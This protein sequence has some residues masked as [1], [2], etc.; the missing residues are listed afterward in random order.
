[1]SK[2]KSLLSELTNQIVAAIEEADFSE[3]KISELIES[4]VSEGQNE[5]FE[6]LKKNAP[7]ML[8]EERRAK[9]S[10]EDRNYRRWKE[11]LDLLR[12]MWV[13]CQEI[14]ESHAH[15]GPLD[16]DELT[17]DTLAHLQPKA[18]LILSEILSLLES[19]FADGALARWRS[20]HEVTV[21]GMFISKHGHEAAL[22]Y[23][24][25]MWF[26]NL[27]AANQYNRH[28]NRANLAPITHAE[29][30][31]IE[32]KCA[33]SRELLG[34]E[35]KSD[36]DWASSILKKTRP[37][38]A[39]LEREVGLDH[40]RPRFKWA[41]QHIH[42]GFVRPDRLLGMTEADNFA[43]QVGASNSGLVE[44]LQ[45]SAISLMQITNTFLL[46]PEPNV[47]RL[48]FANVLAAFSDEIGMV[49]LR[50]KDETLKEALKDA[51]E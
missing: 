13:C 39:D 32:Q 44:P 38:F 24:L 6:S 34:R 25:S 28:A 51:R 23:R 4:I 19:G 35:L 33:E 20:L 27:R 47:D 14:A 36:W 43:F 18:L 3:D 16:G 42:A 30:S 1:M 50:T 45:M 5:L 10:F 41:C 29:V 11:P 26:S 9:R 31:K 21:V 8:K 46:F 2:K 49:A 7:P 12:T 17:F 40:W 48:V 15:E 37:N 22:A